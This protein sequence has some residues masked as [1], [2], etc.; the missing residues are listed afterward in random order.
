MNTLKN[1]VTIVVVTFC[2]SS[3]ILMAQNDALIH[4][5]KFDGNLEDA[6]GDSH[7]VFLDGWWLDPVE[8]NFITGHDGTEKGAL[9]FDGAGGNGYVIYVGRWSAIK[10]G[11]DTSMT[12]TLWGL[13]YGRYDDG[14]QDIINKRDN[15]QPPDMVW[16][17]NNPGPDGNQNLAVKRRGMAADF[18]QGFDVNVWTHIAVTMDGVNVRFY[19]NGVF[20]EEL[21]YVY[22]T[23]GRVRTRHFS[24]L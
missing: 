21:P 2:F 5:Y 17:F 19:K 11:P 7:G 15:Y 9:N 4:Q 18:S 24:I 16:G 12:L 23:G 14:T 1:I 22:G 3:A 13:W 10:E 6:V 8:N 20:I